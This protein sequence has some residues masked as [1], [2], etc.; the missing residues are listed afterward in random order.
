[1]NHPESDQTLRITLLMVYLNAFQ[2]PLMLSAVNVGLPHF[3]SDLQMNAVMLSWVATSYLMASVM[4]VLP[5][6]RLA[7][8]RGRKKIYLSGTLIVALASILAAVCTSG[9]QLVFLRFVQG[10]GGAMIYATQIAILTAVCPPAMRGRAIGKMVSILYL[11]LTCGPLLGGYVVE[12]L[13][14]RALLVM[15]VPLAVIVLL[16]GFFRVP[17]DLQEASSAHMDI[18]GTVCYA[19]S[20]AA[21]C[22]GASLVP[23]VDAWLLLGLGVAG[24]YGFV[25]IEKRVAHP[26]F[27]LSLF[28]GNRTFSLS[29]MA[30]YIMYTATFANVVLIS[31]Y[32]QYLKDLS[33]SQAGLIMMTQ[34]LLMAICAPLAGRLSDTVEPRIIATTGMLL[35]ALGLL[36]LSRFSAETPVSLIVACLCI[37]GIGFGLFSSPNTNAIMGSVEKR[38]YGLASASNATMRLLGQ[39]SSM[40]MVTLILSLILGATEIAPNN[41]PQLQ[42]AI[43][44][45]F[46]LAACLCVP[47]IYFS[48]VR[49]HLHR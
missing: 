41:Y 16:I 8:M 5:F 21:I 22:A 10:I 12:L 39:M 40:L 13:G 25:L 11:G 27:D 42:Q 30:S 49:G 33:A 48:M 32:L 45:S 4:F 2:L 36:L 26:V 6:G 47:G 20:I 24:L 29:C 37:T 1:M 38:H 35:T 17:D 14:W 23:D 19:M 9:D 15:Q 7:D 3:A 34:P 31:L 43:S 44:I 28:L 46:M 18:P